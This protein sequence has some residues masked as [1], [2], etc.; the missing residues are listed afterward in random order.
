MWTCQ[1]LVATKYAFQLIVYYQ[2]MHL[3]LILINLKCQKQ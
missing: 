2:Q 3:M 1:I